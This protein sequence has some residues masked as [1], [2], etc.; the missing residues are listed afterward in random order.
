V[1]P[2]VSAAAPN[3]NTA[4]TA[5][6]CGENQTCAYSGS[7]TYSA[8]IGGTLDNNTVRYTSGQYG[9]GSFIAVQLNSGAAPDAISSTTV[10][11]GV[12]AVTTS[13][14]HHVGLFSTVQITGSSTTNN[15]GTFYVTSVSSPTT[16]SVI[17]PAGV[18]ASSC[19]SSC[20]SAYAAIDQ[21]RVC[22]TQVT[23][24]DLNGLPAI[25]HINPTGIILDN[26][27]ATNFLCPPTQTLN[28]TVLGATAALAQTPLVPAAYTSPAGQWRI[29][30]YISSTVACSV[31]GSP[32]VTFT[33]SFTDDTGPRTISGTGVLLG[34]TGANNQNGGTLVVY[35]SA[36]NPITYST[37]NFAGCTTG[38]ATYNLRTSAE[39]VQ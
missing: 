1:D 32:T 14:P 7:N 36:G 30:W 31:P 19:V 15:N 9:N 12:M 37:T 17:V 26:Q 23:D 8:V 16:F 21:V 39:Q 13:T 3:C 38:T 5:C 33:I 6:V 34:A 4:P 29:N 35:T 10:T 11:A 2:T 18:T 20:G 24:Q 28:A 22:G 25:G 27:Q